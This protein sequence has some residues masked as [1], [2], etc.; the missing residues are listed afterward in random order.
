MTAGAGTRDAEVDV[1]ALDERRCF[2]KDA[3]S[4][5]H[6]EAL[7]K[8]YAASTPFPHVV[9]D[10]LFETRFLE[11]ILDDYGA[12]FGEWIHYKTADEIKTGTRPNAHLGNGAT[13]YFD[14]IHRGRF[15]QFLSHVTG[16]DGLLPDP[17]LFGGGLHEI[18]TGG[19]FSHHVDFNRHPVTRLENR[20]VLITY[21]NKDWIAAY[22]GS[23]ELCDVDT[24]AC[25]AE[26]V[27]IFGRSI[28]FSQSAASLHG[29]PVPVQAPDGRPRRSVAAYYYTNGRTDQQAE[30][31]H[32]THFPVP[33]QFGR[34][35]RLTVTANYVSPLVVDVV[36]SAMRNGAKLWRR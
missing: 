17:S 21:L 30:A 12:G 6:A 29:H 24:R 18:R 34:W 36:R 14:V 25:V 5:G 4:R 2:T 9:I 10:N 20:L 28:L 33:A 31:T 16:I 26:V 7:R 22:G 23:L 15:T 19:R 13:R 8:R 11:A 3:L 35:G 27:P 32:T 1:D